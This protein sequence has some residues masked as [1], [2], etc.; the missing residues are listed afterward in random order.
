MVRPRLRQ[1]WA[2]VGVGCEQNWVRLHL[3]AILVAMKLSKVQLD[4]YHMKD[5]AI[6]DGSR[7]IHEKNNEFQVWKYIQ[8]D[9]ELFIGK[10]LCFLSGIVTSLYHRTHSDKFSPGAQFSGDQ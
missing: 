9:H 8:F 4:F 6:H 5:R 3:I 10:H 1:D 7:L 2:R